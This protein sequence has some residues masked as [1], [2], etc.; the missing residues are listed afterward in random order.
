M[1]LVSPKG[2][3]TPRHVFRAPKSSSH[4]ST[5]LELAPYRGLPPWSLPA[6]LCRL[7]LQ[8]APDIAVPADCTSF[9][10]C[11]HNHKTLPFHSIIGAP[12]SAPPLSRASCN[13]LHG[14]SDLQPPA[15]LSTLPT[16][17]FRETK[18]FNNLSTI[19][20]RNNP[21]GRSRSNLSI[22]SGLLIQSNIHYNQWW[23]VLSTSGLLPGGS[24]LLFCSSA[25]NS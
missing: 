25:T 13:F 7:H 11:C 16:S 20:V 1:N 23:Y 8:L 21:N 22:T 6:F 15:D 10:L 18:T 5:Y 19:S 4:P 24:L 2:K 17:T 14:L 3:Q 12:P 9:A